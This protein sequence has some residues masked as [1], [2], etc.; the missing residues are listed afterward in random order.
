MTQI[1][2]RWNRIGRLLLLLVIVPMIVIVAAILVWYRL[3][4]WLSAP[5]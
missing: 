2:V 4:P 3:H 1:R 5:H